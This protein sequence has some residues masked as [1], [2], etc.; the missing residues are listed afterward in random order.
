MKYTMRKFTTGNEIV[1]AAAY[2]AGAKL[3]C[4][5]PITPTTEILETWASLCVKDKNIGILQTEDE[6]SAGFSLIGS[7]FAGKK[8]FTATA[9]PGNVLI[10]DAF[11]MAEALRLPTVAVI[12]QRGGLST[13]TVIYSQ[14][15]VILTCFGGNGE[16]F[17][18]VYSPSDIQELYNLTFKSFFTAWKYK[19]PTFVL[20]DG[21]LGKMMGEVD[22]T[23]I[24]DLLIDSYPI[25]KPGVNLRNCY[26]LEEEIG[27]IIGDYHKDYLTDR[28]N[29][30]EAEAFMTD[31]AEVVFVA[32]GTV[33]A[34]CKT[35]ISELRK[36]HIKAGLLRPI[37]LRPFP[38]AFMREKLNGKKLII[39]FESAL[40]Q[41]F[42]LFR[43]ERDFDN[44]NIPI[45][46]SN[47][48]SIG[49]SPEEIYDTTKKAM[50]MKGK[51]Q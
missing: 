3:M 10:Q 9:G 22:P 39:F 49:F 18:V 15:E 11:S 40:G 31:D 27:K 44:L 47:K 4:G 48:P 30:E 24:P 28:P 43:R 7:V 26:N 41:L 2:D 29:I 14:E 45:Y 25:L 13:S 1:A 16:G 20:G 35:A 51:L 32:H 38:A 37:T 12:M 33:A 19:W 34:A 36:S 17:R 23:P 21:Y 8:A 46:E 5:Y 42:T 50:S 6:M